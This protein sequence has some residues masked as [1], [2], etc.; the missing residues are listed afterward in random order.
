MLSSFIFSDTFI[1]V[2]VSIKFVM[3]QNKNKTLELILGGGPIEDFTSLENP[4]FRDVLRFYSKFWRVNDSDTSK[5]T[6][7][8]TALKNIYSQR[9]IETLNELTIRRKI[10]KQVLSLKKVLKFKSK[11]KTQVNINMENAFKAQLW[12]IFEIEKSIPQEGD[13][14]NIVPMDVNDQNTE[15]M[16]TLGKVNN[17][18]KQP[19]EILIFQK[20]N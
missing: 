9:N 19:S 16:S 3:S 4:T 6:R 8:A 14:D 13:V 11:E 15:S 7:V 12:N 1:L 18:F 2:K 10:R 5:E 17:C 20:K